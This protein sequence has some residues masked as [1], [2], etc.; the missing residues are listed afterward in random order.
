MSCAMADSGEVTRLLKAW[1][2]GDR[3]ALERL[4]TVVEDELRRLARIHL[5]KEAAGHTLQPTALINEAYVRLL[6]SNAMDWQ[7]RSH[8]FAVASRIM[9]RILVNHALAR[10]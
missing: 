8:F 6:D 3:S 10:K 5:R 2:Q 9:R 4:A 1:S 7:G